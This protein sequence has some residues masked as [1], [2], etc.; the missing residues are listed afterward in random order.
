MPLRSLLG[1]ALLVALLA[2]LAPAQAD[3]AAAL[4]LGGRRLE[5]DGWIYVHLE[6]TPERIGFQ[7]GYLLAKEIAGLLAVE[8]PFLQHET[9]REWSFYR[10]AAE[11]LLWPGIEPEYQTE[12]DGIVAGMKAR[13]E[14]ADRWDLV[15]LNAIEELPGYYSPWL[16]RQQG[17]KPTRSSP[18]NC[19]AFIATGKATRDGR[20]VMGHNA[21][22]DYVIGSRWNIVFDLMPEHGYRLLMDG[23]PGVIVSDDDFALN[24]GGLMVTETTIA[25]FEGFDPKGKPEFARARKAMQY[26]ASIDAFVAIM[27]DGNNGGYANDW[28]LG[29]NHTGEIARFELGLVHH[30]I[31]RTRDGVFVGA[32][33]PVDPRLIADETKFGVDDKTSSPNARRT[34]WEQLLA[35][36]RGRIDVEAGKRFELDTLDATTG[37]DGAN[38]HTLFGAVEVSPRG[39]PQ[40]EWAPFYPGGTAQS[41]VTDGRLAERLE[42]W[43]AMGHPVGPEFRTGTFLQAHPEYEWMRP[44]LQDVTA[45]PWSRFGPDLR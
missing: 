10:Q 41:K 40:W 18:G 25:Q 33:F 44:L 37:V 39:V 7:H 20:I 35:E 12:I 19:S 24:A 2:D 34:R 22:T 27:L 42:F 4:L 45:H 21:W 23:L 8:R 29:D 16:E 31:E 1:N 6:G 15:A 17:K 28:L 9:K 13:G 5:R 30:A 11:T 3:A 38:E 43:A 26:A 32:N 36:W 14:A